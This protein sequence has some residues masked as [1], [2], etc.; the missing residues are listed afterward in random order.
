MKAK[1][2]FLV[3][4]TLSLIFLPS[5]AVHHK[6]QQHMKKSGASFLTLGLN[7][8]KRTDE[9]ARERLSLLQSKQ[10]EIKGAALLQTPPPFINL[11]EQS[12]RIKLPLENHFNT[13]VFFLS[14]SNKII[15]HC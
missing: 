8:H 2:L 7:K 6:K 14:N 10:Q 4:A 11:D 13:I 1:A 5:I 9:K 12:T 3:L 15:V